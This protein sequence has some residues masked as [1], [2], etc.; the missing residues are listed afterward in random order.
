M[1]DIESSIRK[2]ILFFVDLLKKY[3]NEIY[4]K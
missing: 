4:G 3:L 2:D 1:P